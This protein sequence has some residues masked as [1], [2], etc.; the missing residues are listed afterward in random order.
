MCNL[1]N[2]FRLGIVLKVSMKE[3]EF[4]ETL[5]LLKEDCKVKVNVEYALYARM[6]KAEFMRFL[7]RTALLVPLTFIVL[8]EALK[9][10]SKT[11]LFATLVSVLPL[12]NF[13]L[14]F[15]LLSFVAYTL[16]TSLLVSILISLYIAGGE[17]VEMLLSSR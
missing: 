7:V 15:P 9:F 2:L 14:E 8:L 3:R 1:C 17:K 5:N 16:I 13:V 6:R 4:I 12:K 10:V 11:Q